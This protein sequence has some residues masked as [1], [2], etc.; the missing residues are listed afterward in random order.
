MKSYLQSTNSRWI[1]FHNLSVRIFEKHFQIFH[2]SRSV[3]RKYSSLHLSTL[4]TNAMNKSRVYY[5]CAIYKKPSSQLDTFHSNKADIEA[6]HFPWELYDFF[7]NT[8]CF[9]VVFINT[10]LH[11][12]V[13]GCLL[14]NRGN[15][16]IKYMGILNNNVIYFGIKIACFWHTPY[17]TNNAWCKIVAFSV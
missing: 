11:C 17:I 2:V 16:I 7:I 13:F 15:E 14:Q 9:S 12:F 3:S 10:V 1:S 8:S 5:M 6:F 4:Q